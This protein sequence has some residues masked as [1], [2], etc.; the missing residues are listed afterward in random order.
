MW[1]GLSVRSPTHCSSSHVGYWGVLC[2]F[3]NV[4]DIFYMSARVKVVTLFSNV[5][6]DTGEEGVAVPHPAEGGVRGGG[7][8]LR[9]ST[10]VL[11]VPLCGSGE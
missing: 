4:H 2:F 5:R 6:W 3:V 11:V 7:V 8:L 9:G 10:D 1:L